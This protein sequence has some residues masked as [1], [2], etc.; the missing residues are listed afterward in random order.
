[1]AH[2]ISAR[3][4]CH[5]IGATP[6]HTGASQMRSNP[7]HPHAEPTLHMLPLKTWRFFAFGSDVRWPCSASLAFKGFVDF[8]TKVNLECE[9]AKRPQFHRRQFR[10][11]VLQESARFEGSA[12][13]RVEPTR[14]E[15]EPSSGFE[16]GMSR[17]GSDDWC[18]V[19]Y[20]ESPRSS[21]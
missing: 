1:M 14:S 9:Q 19:T 6:R 3:Q 21:E 4:P 13:R 20:I 17:I 2:M 10:R 18:S 11:E 16:P 8:D 12:W 15:S 7:L 5:W